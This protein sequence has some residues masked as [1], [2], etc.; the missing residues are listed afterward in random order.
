MPEGR[1]R[2]FRFEPPRAFHGFDFGA[3]KAGQTGSPDAAFEGAFD[4]SLR[5]SRLPGAPLLRR[6]K[7]VD[8]VQIGGLCRRWMPFPRGASRP[9]LGRGIRMPR[10]PLLQPT[11]RVT[12]TR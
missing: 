11:F 10:T 9:F 4:R 8:L 12:C 1:V 7:T 6:L 2:T 5:T 3:L